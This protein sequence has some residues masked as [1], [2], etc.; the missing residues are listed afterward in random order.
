MRFICRYTSLLRNI[1]LWHRNN[2]VTLLGSYRSQ[3]ILIRSMVFS[4]MI[5]ILNVTEHVI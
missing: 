4:M 3:C 1:V 2:F 5:S